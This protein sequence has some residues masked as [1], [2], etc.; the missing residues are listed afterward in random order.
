M[1][2]S[3]ACPVTRAQAKP[4]AHGRRDGSH[5]ERP[6]A[7]AQAGW[8]NDA[9]AVARLQK[10]AETIG[11]ADEPEDGGVHDAL[12]AE[13]RTRGPLPP[14]VL[15]GL[16]EGKPE[17][18]GAWPSADTAHAFP[19]AAAAGREG[20]PPP[21]IAALLEKAAAGRLTEEELTDLELNS[22]ER[23]PSGWVRQ[24]RMSIRSQRFTSGG[25][26]P[27]AEREPR[28]KVPKWKGAPPPKHS[29]GTPLEAL[30]GTPKSVQEEELVTDYGLSPAGAGTRQTAMLGK[31]RQHRGESDRRLEALQAHG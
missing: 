14:G 18:G 1:W 12:A 29:R 5:T 25:R 4:P 24:I 16:L 10:L 27:G 31:E 22:A 20:D 30:G 23:L 9:E 15:A 26:G 13:L 3:D 11:E 8:G 28:L 2:C 6:S 7:D 17:P 21:V 19:L